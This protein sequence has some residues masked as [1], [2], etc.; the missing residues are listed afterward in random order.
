V[1]NIDWFGVFYNALWILG[2]AVAL[3]AVSYA[4]WRRRLSQPRLTLRQALSQPAF[5]AAWSLGLLLF[6]AGLALSRGPWWQTVAW[7]ALALAFLY[8]GG[9]AL[10]HARRGAHE[11]AK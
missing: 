3:A 9:S 2:L 5:Q 1:S 10:L 11:Q 6:C 7:A 4:D 8:L